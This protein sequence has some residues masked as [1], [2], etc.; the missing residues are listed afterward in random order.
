M[1]Y[2]SELLPR[3]LAE[4][5]SWAKFQEQLINIHGVPLLQDGVVKAKCVG[6]HHPEKIRLCVVDS[7]PS[8]ENQTLRSVV[9]EAGLLS[10]DLDGLTF[11]YGIYLKRGKEGEVGLLRHECRHVFQV[12]LLGSLEEFVRVYANQ[13]VWYGYER[14]SLEVDAQSYENLNR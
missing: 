4:A 10:T 5:V 1:N 11:G 3:I 8:P 9:E 6:V 12:E 7:F 14:A 2:L 13:L